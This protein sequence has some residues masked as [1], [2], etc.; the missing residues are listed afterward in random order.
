MNTA[1]TDHHDKSISIALVEDHYRLREELSVYLSDEGF[2]LQSADGAEE[3]STVLSKHPIDIIILDLNLPDEDGI[4]ICKR[5]RATYPE[6]GIII[7][8]ARVTNADRTSG[9]TAGADVYLT[10]PS[11]PSELTAVIKNLSRRLLRTAPLLGWS[12]H[13]KTQQLISPSGNRLT[14]S[15][16]ETLI[17]HELSLSEPYASKEK[18][19]THFADATETDRNSIIRLQVMISRLRT[20]INSLEDTELDIKAVRGMGYQLCADLQIK[21]TSL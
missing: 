16:T 20:K 12:L 10:K 2:Y 11:R 21:N 18:L 4:S 13:I 8:T 14:L 17:L 3:L 15:H 5:I 19:L 7:L 1:L 6:I 9:Y